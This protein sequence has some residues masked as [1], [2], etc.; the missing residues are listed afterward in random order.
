M[1]VGRIRAASVLAGRAFCLGVLCAGP[2]LTAQDRPFGQ[3]EF[4]VF[5][6]A[7]QSFH[8]EEGQG[9]AEFGSPVVQWGRF[10]SRR[11]DALVECHP[12]FVVNQPRLPPDGE[13]ERVEAFAVDVGLRWNFGPEA[14]RPKLYVEVLDGPYYAL[15]RVPAHGTAFNFLTRA[16]AGIRFPIGK[17]W[18]PFVQYR[19]VHISN[20]GI[21]R[22]NPDRDF[23][24]L[25]IGGSLVL[26]DR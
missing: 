1:P 26:P 2:P 24:G 5:I 6:A 18:H 19:W 25:L 20:A 23:H 4:R 21:G 11:V 12:L 15:R 16:G 3:Q 22:F 17:A 7:G 14:W 13:R 10:L 8:N 9:F